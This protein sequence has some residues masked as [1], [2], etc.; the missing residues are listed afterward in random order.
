MVLKATLAFAVFS[1]RNSNFF[2]GYGS[3]GSYS[4]A[5]DS[6]SAS[7][8]ISFSKATD[9]ISAALQGGREPNKEPSKR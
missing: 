9:S 3:S 4:T 6:V 8:S 5:I 1:L 7:S 2:Q